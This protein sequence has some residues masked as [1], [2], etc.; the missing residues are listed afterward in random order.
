MHL[1]KNAQ[2]LMDGLEVTIASLLVAAA[3]TSI[4]PGWPTDDSSK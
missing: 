1:M 3:L 2:R 4:L